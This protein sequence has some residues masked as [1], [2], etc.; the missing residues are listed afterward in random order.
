[1]KLKTLGFGLF[2]LLGLRAGAEAQLLGPLPS[3]GGGGGFTIG[4]PV[5]GG[6]PGDAL[7]VDSSGNVGQV[8][9]TGTGLNV[10]QTS[11]TI[12]GTLTLGTLPITGSTNTIKFGLDSATPQ[13]LSI[14]VSDPLAGNVNVAGA[15][16]TVFGG[17]TTGNGVPGA[18]D[19]QLGGIGTVGGTTVNGFFDAMVLSST[20]NGQ[21]LLSIPTGGVSINGATIG[22]FA[23]NVT[24]TGNVSGD[25]TAN[26][27]IANA[28]ILIEGA[29]AFTNPIRWVG[30]TAL[31][32]NG[33]GT[34]GVSNNAQ[35]NVAYLTIPVSGTFQFGQA[36]AAA[37][38]AQTLQFQ[39]VAAGN[40]NTAGV[41]TTFNASRS[42]GTGAAGNFT[43][44]LS[45]FNAASGTQNT[46]FSAMTLGSTFTG[47]ATLSFPAN[48]ATI[49]GVQEYGIG[50]AAVGGNW[51]A[52]VLQLPNNS[53]FAFSSTTTSTAARDTSISRASAGVLQ[54]G[55]SNSNNGNGSILAAQFILPVTTAP[56]PASGQANLYTVRGTSG[57]GFC[58]LVYQT[59]TTTQV[60][61]ANIAGTGC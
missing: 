52:T 18:I 53:A 25:F 44:Q 17:R 30:G 35:T 10:L 2:L 48:N 32:S 57:A 49:V 54:V 7:F 4:S 5:I 22:A 51:F 59:A 15:K 33:D 40:A 24:G 37:P 47:A 12:L 27:L 26:R 55:N 45:N 50:S 21:V 46:L 11:P 1:M 6:T 41:N 23:L 28:Q 29:S 34:L 9:N 39:G 43:W 61:A 16:I 20:V 36:D 42:N 56:T 19:F 14:D 38:V 3:S 60:I 8:G 13:G 31:I 58:S